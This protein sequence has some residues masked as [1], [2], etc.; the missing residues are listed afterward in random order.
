MK[1]AS[2]LC[3][4]SA[5]HKWSWATGSPDGHWPLCLF[6]LKT[7]H[8]FI[9]LMSQTTEWFLHFLPSDLLFSLCFVLEMLIQDSNTKSG[10]GPNV[11]ILHSTDCYHYCNCYSLWMRRNPHERTLENTHLNSICKE[12]KPEAL[13]YPIYTKIL[14]KNR[15]ERALFLPGSVVSDAFCSQRCLKRSF[16]GYR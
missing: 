13:K 5:W 2:V 8:Y 14:L 7:S 4:K 1:L 11:A 6:I 10:Y 15:E 9:F 3:S 12:Y 16:C